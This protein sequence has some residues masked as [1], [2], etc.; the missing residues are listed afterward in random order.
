MLSLIASDMPRLLRSKDNPRREVSISLVNQILAEDIQLFTSNRSLL[1]SSRS[2]KSLDAPCLPFDLRF[3]SNGLI[4]HQSGP[5]VPPALN[6]PLPVHASG[7]HK[8][9]LIYPGLDICPFAGGQDEPAL[10]PCEWHEN[11]FGQSTRPPDL[12]PPVGRLS[13]TSVELI[14]TSH[15]C[16][17][18]S[19]L[20]ISRHEETSCFGEESA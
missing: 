11:I 17:D 9:K 8:R 13:A 16:V 2:A 20:P 4:K 3:L 12:T 15:C 14:L 5:L 18:F 19:R 6:N 10:R 7:L 1:V